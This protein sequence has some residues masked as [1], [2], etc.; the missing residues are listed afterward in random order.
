MPEDPK[1]TGTFDKTTKKG[2]LILNLYIGGEYMGRYKMYNQN[3]DRLEQ[4]A[5]LGVSAMQNVTLDPIDTD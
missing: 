2:T 1:I 3:G 5:V 4:D